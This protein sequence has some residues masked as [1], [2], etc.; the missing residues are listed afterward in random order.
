MLTEGS[1]YRNRRGRDISF[2][3]PFDNYCSRS[4]SKQDSPSIAV[5]SVN[6][7]YREKNRNF[8]PLHNL[9]YKYLPHNYIS[10]EKKDKKYHQKDINEQ[11][12]AINSKI[13][14]LLSSIDQEE[15]NKQI[16]N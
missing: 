12:E 14:N 11:S 10:P 15:K 5:E 13:K 1:G 6:E 8:S 3:K 16:Y 9:H 7:L 4:G 2:S